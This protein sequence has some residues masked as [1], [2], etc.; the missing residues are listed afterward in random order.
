MGSKFTEL[1]RATEAVKAELRRILDVYDAAEVLELLTASAVLYNGAQTLTS[2]QKAQA[3]A[4]LGLPSLN[5]WGATTDPLVT[6]D[7]AGGYSAGSIWINTVA[8]EAYRCTD[9]TNGAAVWVETT[10]EASEVLSILADYLPLAGGVMTGDIIAGLNGGELRDFGNIVALDW[11]TRGLYSSL[12]ID[13]VVDWENS[14]LKAANLESVNWASRYLADRDGD[15]SLDWG[16]YYMMDG[17]NQMSIDWGARKLH[18][19]ASNSIYDWSSGKLLGDGTGLSGLLP[20]AGGTMDTG[21]SVGWASSDFSLYHTGVYRTSTALE[22]V[23]WYDCFLRDSA[24]VLSVNWG[25]RYLIDSSDLPS[26]DWTNRCLYDASSPFPY[27]VLDWNTKTMSDGANDSL[28]WYE[29]ELRN[30]GGIRTVDWNDCELHDG[31]NTSVDWAS[32]NLKDVDG[33]PILDWTNTTGG[34]LVV[35]YSPFTLANF[36]TSVTMPTGIL[37]S[38]AIFTDG[39]AASLVGSP[40]AAGG[41]V[42]VQVTHNGTD[43]I[44]TA[45]L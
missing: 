45:F 5:N 17:M 39:D 13:P 16:N 11:D 3:L 7:T 42:K 35:L 19:T 31:T 41:A 27:I 10:L 24:G 12:D 2:P 15:P 14:K 6:D 23:S 25:N 30:A 32:R 44:V 22:V 21:A 29:R 28:N 18:D 43:W 4:N 1:S 40:F 37:G 36:D 33:N 26:V 8:K 34:G 38:M 9:A 20:L